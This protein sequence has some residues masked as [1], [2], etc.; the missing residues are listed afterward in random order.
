MDLKK[1]SETL[2]YVLAIE[3]KNSL[4]AT[5]NGNEVD[6]RGFRSASFILNTGIADG[7]P[8]SWSIAYTVQEREGAADDWATAVDAAGSNITGTLAGSSDAYEKVAIDVDLERQKRRMRIVA[9]LAFTGGT[10]PTLPFAC[11]AVL[12]NPFITPVTQGTL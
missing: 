1:Q 10:T 4:A 6:G 5:V 8:V 12:G 3:P 2:K 9:V 11:M 7:D